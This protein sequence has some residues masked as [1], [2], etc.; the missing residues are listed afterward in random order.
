[1]TLTANQIRNMI[2]KNDHIHFGFDS[3]SHFLMVN[4][5]KTAEFKTRK[6]LQHSINKA[7]RMRLGLG[8][9]EQFNESQDLTSGLNI[10]V[11][12]N[13]NPFAGS[14]ITDGKSI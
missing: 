9:P 1:M 8:G 12:N 11:A 14:L 13:E 2:A 7:R 5:K 10:A 3:G 4:G 6:E